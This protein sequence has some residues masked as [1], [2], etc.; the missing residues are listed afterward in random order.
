MY[1]SVGGGSDSL[2][3]EEAKHQKIQLCQSLL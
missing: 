2:G 3:G 1:V